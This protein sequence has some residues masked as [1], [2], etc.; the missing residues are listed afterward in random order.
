MKSVW[1]PNP[2][3]YIHDGKNYDKLS[4]LS[5]ICLSYRIAFGVFH[6]QHGGYGGLNEITMR[7]TM[8]VNTSTNYYIVKPS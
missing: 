3:E 6:T 8:M 5:S 2:E 7:M 1:F 4:E